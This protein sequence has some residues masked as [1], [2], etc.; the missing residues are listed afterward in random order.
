MFAFYITPFDNCTTCTCIYDIYA[1]T[2]TSKFRSIAPLKYVF[3]D[4]S[5]G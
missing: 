1:C 2:C 5:A 3:N 4:I